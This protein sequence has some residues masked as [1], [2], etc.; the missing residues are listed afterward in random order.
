[1]EKLRKRLLKIL[2][3]NNLHKKI[4]LID[5]LH[6]EGFGN[7]VGRVNLLYEYAHE[8]HRNLGNGRVYCNSEEEA[9]KRI[10]DYIKKYWWFEDGVKDT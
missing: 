4:Y 1:V 8:L 5:L 7:K 6:H 9:M 10:N 2:D 3:E